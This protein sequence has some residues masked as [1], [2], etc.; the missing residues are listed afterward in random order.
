MTIQW[1]KFISE[2]TNS[3]KIQANRFHGR[4]S[5][6]DEPG[7]KETASVLVLAV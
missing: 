7:E 4:L 2:S 1:K 6:I 3:L 5:V